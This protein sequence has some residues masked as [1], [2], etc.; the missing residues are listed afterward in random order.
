MFIFLGLVFMGKKH[1]I[2]ADCQG[3]V[4]ENTAFF[5]FSGIKKVSLEYIKAIVVRQLSRGNGRIEIVT[6][7]G[8]ENT[9]IAGPLKQ[10]RQGAS[11]L[12]EILSVPLEDRQDSIS[13]G[14]VER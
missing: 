1:V 2:K 3:L 14:G 10:I 12:S 9:L 6:S 7:A 4:I 13:A 5:V 11:A 8:I